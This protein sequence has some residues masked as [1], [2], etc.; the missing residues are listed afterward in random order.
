MVV[1]LEVQTHNLITSSLTSSSFD[2]SVNL[3]THHHRHR[4]QTHLSLS[5]G[6]HFLRHHHH[7]LLLR[8]QLLHHQ[9]LHHHPPPPH[10]DCRHALN[11][12][13]REQEAS[14]DWMTHNP[15]SSHKG[16]V[17]ISHYPQCHPLK[18]NKPSVYYY[19]TLIPRE[20]LSSNSKHNVFLINFDPF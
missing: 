4:H 15:G 2:A 11:K 12:K 19:N 20:S 3:H 14:G 18:H 1:V 17:D 16:W 7:L 10:T 8:H 6:H 13:C 5:A 9:L